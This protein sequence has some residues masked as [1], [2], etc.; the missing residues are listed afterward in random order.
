MI[1]AIVFDHRDGSAT[2]YAPALML[3]AASPG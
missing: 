3:I 2:E 1:E